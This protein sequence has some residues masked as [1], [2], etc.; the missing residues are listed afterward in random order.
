MDVP[1]AWPIWDCSPASTTLLA[2]SM[3]HVLY[4]AET[5]FYSLLV[6]TAVV[7]LWAFA[8]LLDE[9]D[10]GRRWLLWAAASAAGG[11][12]GLYG[13]FLLGAGGS[14]AKPTAGC[15]SSSRSGV[16]DALEPAG[17]ELRSRASARG[18]AAGSAGTP[19]QSPRRSRLG[20]TPRAT[21]GRWRRGRDWRAGRSACPACACTPPPP[22]RGAAPTPRRRTARSGSP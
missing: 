22:G 4:A 18:R 9:P 13:L 1:C 17:N 5:R 19:G 2:V 21:S 12:T 15:S 3:P 16:G 14:S 10:R 7:D 11:A 20:C 6:L 8:W